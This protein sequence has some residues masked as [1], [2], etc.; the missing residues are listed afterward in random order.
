MDSNELTQHDIFMKLFLEN[1]RGLL[2]YVMC[3]VPNVY[4]ARDIV[5]NTSIA[6]WRKI[7]QYD[8]EQPFMP[9]AC[10]FALIETREFLRTQVRWR[11]FL[12]DDVVQTLL[13]RRMEMSEELDE[14]RIHLRECLRKLPET[15]R[16][17]VEDY[18]FDDRPIEQLAEAV[19]KSVDAIYKS[20]QRIRTALMECIQRQQRLS[21]GDR[22]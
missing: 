16:T 22:R 2:R 9:W 1:Q 15:Q 17:V 4:D 13:S 6:L 3:L 14:R 7:D 18:Y 10:Q 12:D 11:R 19:N 20:L 5:Q 8:Y 21:V